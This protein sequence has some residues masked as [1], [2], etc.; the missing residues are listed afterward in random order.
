MKDMKHIDLFSGIG[1]FALAIDNIFYE[2]KNEHI[3]CDNDKFCQA[4]LKKHWPEAQIIGDIRTFT[5]AE[6]EQ[7]H[8]PEQRGL[9]TKPG[10]QDSGSGIIANTRSE[11]SGRLSSSEREALAEARKS[12]VFILTG[13]FPCQPFSQAGRRKGTADDRYLWPEMF[14]VIRD[15][16]PTWV[17]GENVRGLVTWNE[18]MVLEQVCADLE[19][20]GYEV[21]PIIIPAVAVNAPHRRDRVWIVA[22]TTDGGRG[23][24][25]TTKN[26][27]GHATQP[28]HAGKLEGGFERPH[29]NAPNSRL[30]YGSERRDERMETDK[31]KR[32]TCPTDSE[33]QSENGGDVADS[34]SK[35]G[36]R[37]KPRKP[38]KPTQ[39]EEGLFRRDDSGDDSDTINERLQGSKHEG[40]S[41]HSGQ[42]DRNRSNQRPDWNENWLEVATRL[43]GVHDGFSGWMDRFMN[44]VICLKDYENTQKDGGEALRILR[45]AFQSEAFRQKIGGFYSLDGKDILLEVVC[46][47]ERRVLQQKRIYDSGAETSQDK[48]WSMWEWTRSRCASQGRQYNEQYARKLSDALPQLPYEIALEI[49][50]VGDYLRS[51]YKAIYRQEAVVGDKKIKNTRNAA[52]KAAGNAIVPAVA[53]QILKAIKQNVLF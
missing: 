39:S 15:F 35:G 18:G 53:E 36:E 6:S 14:R 9:H 16:K 11:E 38:R 47:L 49:T 29:S 42:P 28:E 22:N 8:A 40:G 19:S 7:T 34:S 44:D 21:Q 45:E 10:I 5:N 4:V 37:R 33:R 25:K 24:G 46:Q 20:I 50:Q 31:A 30:Q 41:G 2:E 48:V 23:D 1:G 51:A 17:I 3:F 12:G 32:T 26:E 27:K 43:C 13:G 52:L